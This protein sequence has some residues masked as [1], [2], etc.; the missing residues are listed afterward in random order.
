MDKQRF[1]GWLMVFFLALLLPA[2]LLIQQSYSRLK[3]ETFHNYQKMASEFSQ[4]IDTKLSQLI[5]DEDKRSFADY[6]FFNAA[7]DVKSNL[8]RRSPLSNYPI[9]SAIPGVLGYFQVDT[10]GQLTT[11]LLPMSG[12]SNSG[13]N[14]QELNQRVAIQR[15]LQ[16]I[17][18]ANKLVSAALS[19]PFVASLEETLGV[20]GALAEEFSEADV[21]MSDS[22]VMPE[23]AET[24]P[25]KPSP[26]AF[27]Q[28]KER[29][30]QVATKNNY[31]RVEDIQF[32]Q[33][34]QQKSEATEQKKAK[35]QSA[36]QASKLAAPK[37]SV[38]IR[39]F[40]S[41]IDP[42]EFSQLDSG[43]FVLFRKVWLNGQRYTQ[44]L[45]IQQ[46]QFLS[47]IR[48]EFLRTG[49]SQMSS[50]LV[51]Y[52][53][54]LLSNYSEV[55]QESY[56]LS[57]KALTGEA[58][59]QVRLSAPLSDLQMIYTIT[60]LPAGPGGRLV[61][62][63]ALIMASVLI[64]GFYLMYRLGMGQINLANQQQDFVSAISHELKTPLTSIRMYGEILK[65]GWATEDKKRSYYDFI[66]DESE[67]LSRL[68][69]NVLQI[70]RMDRNEQIPQL[71][72]CNVQ[73]LL[74]EIQ[75]KVASQ[76]K[77]A[78]FKLVI[79]SD[80]LLSDVGINID[81][82]WLIQIMI[83]LVDNALKFSANAERKEVILKISYIDKQQVQ[84]TVRDF[85]PGIDK[86]QMKAI[87]KL[88]Y[89]SENELTRD[90]VGTGIGLSL[91]HQMVNSM[92]GKVSV[93]SKESSLIQPKFP[94]ATF[95]VLFPV[96]MIL[97]IP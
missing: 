9:E 54:N 27:E 77:S 93:Q 20:Q 12:V 62:W 46:A 53:G 89:R 79:E 75:A 86:Q 72:V 96:V 26:L 88:F 63:L 16:E 34:Y 8:V 76:V 47:L 95:N 44:G 60:D 65:Q 74:L 78:H 37:S 82:D 90:T 64:G 43:H 58:L 52:Q 22:I 94:G 5:D 7:S 48:D 10:E 28:L 71:S 59:Y 23:P 21:V 67:R 69:N 73:E 11:P 36:K 4:R 18:M 24:E 3:W 1:R 35:Q 38:R 66:Y 56:S 49:L 57:S 41:D 6:S 51:A 45:L 15:E 50:L 19:E 42:F 25:V 14:V 68:I 70:A 33:S 87:F 29:S 39:T 55:E 80:G 30:K 84:F 40:E 91:V 97:D 92:G 13:L 83:N 85:G 31:A 32:K 61:L 81:R 2:A 17:L